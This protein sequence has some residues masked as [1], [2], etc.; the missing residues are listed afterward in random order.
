[1][2]IGLYHLNVIDFL[3]SVACSLPISNLFCSDTYT[4]R[5]VGWHV[6]DCVWENVYYLWLR[7]VENARRRSVAKTVTGGGLPEVL[8]CRDLEP[9]SLE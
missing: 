8:S 3:V 2:N 1:M 9:K 4:G 7:M 6:D 5:L